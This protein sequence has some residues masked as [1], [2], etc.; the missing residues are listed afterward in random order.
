M[1]SIAYIKTHLIE[2]ISEKFALSEKEQNAIFLKFEDS[3]G[4]GDLSCNA[5]FIVANKTSG[6]AAKIAKQIISLIT[7]AMIDDYE[8]KLAMHIKHASVAGSGFV[9][10]TLTEETWHTTAHELAVHPEQCFKLFDDQPRKKYLVEFVSANPTGPLSIAHGRNGIIGDTLVRVL[11]FLGHTAKAEFYVNDAGQQIEN[12]GLSLQAKCFDLLNVDR[13]QSVKLE[14]DNEY[15]QKAAQDCVDEFGADLKNKDLDFF[16]NYGKEYFLEKIEKDLKDY[17]INFHAWQSE[18][19][20]VQS[21]KVAESL[22]ELE[23]KGLLFKQDGA[24]WFKSTDFGDDK[25]RV[26]KKQDGSLT[27][28]ASD[29]AYH[30]EK[31]QRGFDYIIDVLGQDHHSYATRLRATMQAL[32]FDVDK[33]KIIIYQLIRMKQG[34]ELVRMSKRSGAFISL[35]DVVSSIGADAARF[36][37]LNKKAEAHLELD[38]D[39]AKKQDS[40]NPVYYIQYAYVRIKSIL[41][42]AAQIDSLKDYAEKLINKNLNEVDYLKLEHNFD[43]DEINLIKQVSGLRDALF[44]IERTFQAH[45]LASH[46]IFLAKAF[47]SYYNSNKIVDDQD[48]TL[49]RSR[50]LVA[51]IVKNTLGLCLD[52]LGLSKPDKM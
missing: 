17:K 34:E 43:D 33:F 18:K 31:F 51:D 16:K 25:D 38:C 20:L 24:I 2:L 14:Y 8:N 9:N 42:K 28:V 26:I 39:L 30:K 45:L 49:T 27:Y 21:G 36:F 6:S 1:N 19:E 44:A 41:D 23:S 50:L 22:R 46:T 11:N 35:A 52:L 32:D 13:D 12:L 40:D 4:H 7:S 5:A 3:K 10:I 48:L 47:H 37:Y 29:I 15:L